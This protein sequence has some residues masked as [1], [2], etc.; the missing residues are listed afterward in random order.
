[1]ESC[2]ADRKVH[3]PLIGPSQNT[4][5]NEERLFSKGAVAK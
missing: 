2:K 3:D 5:P 4:L 1:M